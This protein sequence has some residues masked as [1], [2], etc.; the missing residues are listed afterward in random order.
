MIA[1]LSCSGSPSGRSAI[2]GN[3]NTV[4]AE[5][6]TRSADTNLGTIEGSSGSA[7]RRRSD[8]IA[9]VR[10][11]QRIGVQSPAGKRTEPIESVAQANNF[12]D[13]E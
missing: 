5:V 3:T 7:L 8:R 1:A 6:N 4:M 13:D 12:A 10:M 2:W 9:N 11:T